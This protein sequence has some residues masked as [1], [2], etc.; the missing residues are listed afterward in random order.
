MMNTVEQEV[1]GQSDSVVWKESICRL[2]LSLQ[3]TKCVLHS[4]VKM[5]KKSVENVFD[6]RP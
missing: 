1:Q 2:A 6:N 4:L 3:G 5:E